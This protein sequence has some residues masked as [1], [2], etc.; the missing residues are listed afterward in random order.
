SVFAA[1]IEGLANDEED[2]VATSP[3]HRDETQNLL[4]VEAV[5]GV[6]R[7][8]RRICARRRGLRLQ[9]RYGP[10]PFPARGGV[11][12]DHT[13]VA[14]GEGIGEIKSPDAEIDDVGRERQSAL[15]QQASD[16][17]DAKGVVAAKY[18]A[19]AG[20]ENAAHDSA[21]PSSGVTSSSEKKKRW[22][23]KPCSPSS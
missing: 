10:R 20:D 17:L 23:G 21:P 11:G 12:D 2:P 4:G 8:V 1:K 19:D 13:V 5:R 3:E 18:V 22:P 7:G 6:G 9:Q 14:V 15:A 16:D